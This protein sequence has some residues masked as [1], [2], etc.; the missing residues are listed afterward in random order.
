M[1][2]YGGL[3]HPWAI[4]VINRTR[5]PGPLSA[6]QPPFLNS[7][8]SWFCQLIMHFVLSLKGCF[9]ETKLLI[10]SATAIK[11]CSIVLLLGNSREN[12][13]A[14]TNLC[15]FVQYHESSKENHLCII[16]DL[17]PS[18]PTVN[19]YLILVVGIQVSFPILLCKFEIL[20]KLGKNN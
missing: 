10:W 20:H 13:A 5:I 15:A 18:W 1:P 12:T 7:C 8:P 16:G 17:K 14:A 3:P 2:I 6:L 11:Y 19:I 9:L 4:A